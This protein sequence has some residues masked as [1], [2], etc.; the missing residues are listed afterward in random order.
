MNIVS[1]W[2]LELSWTLGNRD[3]GVWIW[4][5]IWVQRSQVKK[6]ISHKNIEISIFMPKEGQ[7]V[8]DRV[9]PGQRNSN[10]RVQR[11]KKHWY[12]K[13]T[14]LQENA[15]PVAHNDQSGW[16][17]L[18]WTN[19]IEAPLKPTNGIEGPL[20]STNQIGG[21]KIDQSDWGTLKLTNQI[22][23]PLK[24]TNQI[25]GLLKLTN[26]MILDSIVCLFRFFI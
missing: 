7:M 24:P 21:P 3:Q 26:Q 4:S 25:E 1:H 15:R 13:S 17:T 11:S 20:K 9:L 8:D 6:N 5:Q 12:E 10:F 2:R 23:G 18:K 19:Q 16:G 22:E 14:K